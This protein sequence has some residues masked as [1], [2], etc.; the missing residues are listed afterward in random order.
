[1][2]CHS[3]DG[4]TRTLRNGRMCQAERG[5]VRASDMEFWKTNPTAEP[6]AS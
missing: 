5:G 4:I 6:P 2:E 3:W 1:M